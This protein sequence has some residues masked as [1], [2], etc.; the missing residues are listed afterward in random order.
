MRK[1]PYYKKFYKHGISIYYYNESGLYLYK[2]NGLFRFSGD[3]T[4]TFFLDKVQWDSEGNLIEFRF[5]DD[6]EELYY[7]H[8]YGWIGISV[9]D[10]NYDRRI[11]YFDNE[12]RKSGEWIEKDTNQLKMFFHPNNNVR[13]LIS[14]KY[15]NEYNGKYRYYHENGQVFIRGEFYCDE[16]MADTLS[17]SNPDNFKDGKWEYYDDSGAWIKSEF[18]TKGKLVEE[19]VDKKRLK[20]FINSGIYRD[21]E[22]HVSFEEIIGQYY[23]LTYVTN[24]NNAPVLKD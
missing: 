22:M 3:T 23:P 24:Y 11:L 7:H 8:A 16:A 10:K 20:Q 12:G 13:E 5:W 19:K 17:L 4:T 21:Y 2:N 15:F 6:K 14:L 18:Y 9:F 1:N